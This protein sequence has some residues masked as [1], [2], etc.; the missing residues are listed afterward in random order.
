[1]NGFADK[2]DD[3]SDENVEKI[4]KSKTFESRSQ[5]TNKIEDYLEDKREKI[6]TKETNSR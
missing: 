2:A 4:K 3:F 1:M 5:G 6:K